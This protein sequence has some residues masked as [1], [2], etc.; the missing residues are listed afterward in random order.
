MKIGDL[1][2]ELKLTS[3]QIQQRVAELGSELN[4]HYQ[5][6]TPVF[7]GVLS[8]SFMFLGDLMKTVNIPAEVSFV[9]LAS[10]EGAQ[11]SGS[12]QTQLGL[13]IDIAGRDVV[14][15]EDIVDTGHTV[16]FLIKML[17]Q[18]QPN[19]IRVCSLLYKPEACQHDFTELKYVGFEIP[20]DFVVGYGLDYN[21]LGRNLNDIYQLASN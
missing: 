4:T 3:A 1:N 13:T 20:N 16:A 21:G 5:Q 8:G 15:V 19:S 11:S 17:Q 18:E 7:I 9:K 14:I 6:K 10:Y 12:I 2:F